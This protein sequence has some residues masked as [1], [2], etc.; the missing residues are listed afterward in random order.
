[1]YIVENNLLTKNIEALDKQLLSMISEVLSK[2]NSLS[3][4][5]ILITSLCKEFEVRKQDTIRQFF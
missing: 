2:D 3:S 4:K 1:M 5:T